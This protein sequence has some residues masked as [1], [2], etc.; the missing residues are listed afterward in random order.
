MG[1]ALGLLVVGFARRRG[2]AAE[3]P[4]LLGCA[5]LVAAGLV[6]WNH[7]P[8]WVHQLDRQPPWADGFPRP[9]AAV[10]PGLY[11]LVQGFLLPTE[12][13]WWLSARDW[14]GHAYFVA[15]SAAG[16]FLLYL[17]AAGQYA[18]L[19]WVLPRVAVIGAALA[20]ERGVP[21]AAL[22]AFRHCST[23]TCYGTVPAVNAWAQ[24]VLALTAV[25]ILAVASRRLA[26][27]VSPAPPA[28]PVAVLCTVALF[29][30]GCGVNEVV[31]ASTRL[32]P[33]GPVSAAV[34]LYRQEGA[35]PARTAAIPSPAQARSLARAFDRLLP[36]PYM[37]SCPA[38][39]P[40]DVVFRY[41]RRSPVTV[42][43]GTCDV[44]SR[45]R[46][47]QWI[48]PHV[49]SAAVYEQLAPFTQGL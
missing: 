30:S 11:R 43:V 27:P 24:C 39:P 45:A 1:A 35:A 32:V 41:A 8:W 6:V 29:L 46:G 31:T 5:V 18:R 47:T 17:A 16:F 40:V 4:W 15:L 14:A 9:P 19:R 33:P 3:W 37:F 49:A 20:L 26:A 22:A 38:V 13:P 44:A 7:L 12:S 28:P 10:P 48:Y 21:F 34:L 2:S 36:P 23:L 42:R 25:P